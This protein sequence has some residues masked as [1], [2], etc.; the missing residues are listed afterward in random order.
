[1]NTVLSVARI[2]EILQTVDD[3]EIGIN[4]VDLGFVYR[5]DSRQGRIDIQLALTSNVCP[6]RDTILDWIRQ[7]LGEETEQEIAIDT[8]SAS[9]WTPARMSPT[10]S[11]ADEE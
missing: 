10:V 6:M 7:A 8:E 3:P 2:Y 5:V 1:M 9:P 4:I 11:R